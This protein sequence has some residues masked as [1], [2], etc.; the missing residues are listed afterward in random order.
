MLIHA[1]ENVYKD[2]KYE[3]AFTQL[4]YLKEH[5]TCDN[6]HMSTHTDE[7]VFKCTECEN[8]FEDVDSLNGH[9]TTHIS[10]SNETAFSH[11]NNFNKNTMIHTE[12]KLHCTECQMTFS[13]IEGLREHMTIIHNSY[14]QYKCT[15]CEMTFTD[16][17]YFNMHRATHD[18]KLYQCSEYEVFRDTNLVQN[19]M[20]IPKQEP[21]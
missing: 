12:E 21:S 3:N 15:I 18:E 6:R 8:V 11:V 5:E 4:E 7:K 14:E 20:I 19:H 2:I 17:S 16:L 9:M 10:E 1:D 13:Q